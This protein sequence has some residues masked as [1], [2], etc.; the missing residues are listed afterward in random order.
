MPHGFVIWSVYQ[1][2]PRKQ[3][4]TK[5]KTNNKTP[6]RGEPNLKDLSLGLCVCNSE[7]GGLEQQSRTTFG[8]EGQTSPTCNG[9]TFSV[10]KKGI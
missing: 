8:Y 1:K 4:A 5:P 9:I 2:K 3:K 10:I 6:K 7:E